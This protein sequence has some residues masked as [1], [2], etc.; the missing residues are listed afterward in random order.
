[1][2]LIERE[3]STIRSVSGPLLFVEGLSGARVGEMCGVRLSCGEMRSG[4]ILEL[5]GD[6]SIIQVL[7][8]TR[9]IDVVNAS[10]LPK[11]KLAEAGFSMEILGRV[12]NGLGEPV[13]DMPPIIAEKYMEINGLPINPAARQRP[14]LFIETGV[15]AIDGLNTLVR[16][17]KLPIFS[18]AGLPANE[19]AMQIVKQARV[20]TGEEFCVVFGAMGITSRDA[21]FFREGLEAAGSM[22]RTVSYINLASEPII[23]KLFTP[24]IALSAAEYLAFEKG[25]QVMVVLTDMTS[26]C[27]AL[28]VIGSARDEIPG[29]RSYPGYMYTD[30]A[31]IYERAG[32]DK[33]L[34]R[35]G[36]DNADRHHARRR[37]YAPDP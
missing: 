3:F 30:L 20:A 17:Q 14:D 33:G 7:E 9:G 35:V 29:R 18:G 37:H 11:G 6:T 31:S 22:A 12:F 10:V 1:M 28:R 26:Y 16:G 19:L 5:S 15:S 23:E 8:G 32:E 36:Y 27:D 24:R 13:D 25:Y 2:D 34:L 21:F 4:Q